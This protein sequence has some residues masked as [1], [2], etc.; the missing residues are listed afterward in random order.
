MALCCIHA[1]SS[2]IYILWFRCEKR[3]HLLYDDPFWE[4]SL[5]I[6]SIYQF[7]KHQICCCTTVSFTSVWWFF[8]N[9][10]WNASRSRMLILIMG[11][12]FVA[13]TTNQRCMLC[14][15][16]WCKGSLNDV[17][18]LWCMGSGC[19]SYRQTDNLA[20][21]FLAD[22]MWNR[23]NN[24]VISFLFFVLGKLKL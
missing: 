15:F 12:A 1:H 4:K 20:G 17:W 19:F 22:G 13:A 7:F 8:Y 9:G 5:S 16:K 18:L 6:K 11:L 10:E 21:T 3:T 14:C 2:Y 24:I 23:R